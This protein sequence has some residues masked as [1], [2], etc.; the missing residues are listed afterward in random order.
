[1]NKQ[2]SLAMARKRRRGLLLFDGKKY[3]ITKIPHNYMIKIKIDHKK[4]FRSINRDCYSPLEN[5]L[6]SAHE[7]AKYMISKYFK[8]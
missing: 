4:N 7:T 5:G 8:N 2:Q 3:S 1:M 6:S